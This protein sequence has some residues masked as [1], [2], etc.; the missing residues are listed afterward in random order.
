MGELPR[1]SSGTVPVW[2][3]LLRWY[4]LLDCSLTAWTMAIALSAIDWSPDAR[5]APALPR[6]KFHHTLPNSSVPSHST[7]WKCL[8]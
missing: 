8:L 1:L 3:T 6:W 7:L 2:G 4:L 5:W